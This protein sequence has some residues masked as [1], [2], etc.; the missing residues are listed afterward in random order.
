[1]GLVEYRKA[2]IENALR[3]EPDTLAAF[4]RAENYR[5]IVNGRACTI[6]HINPNSVSNRHCAVVD[7]ERIYGPGMEADTA[8]IS[9]IRNALKLKEPE[10]SEVPA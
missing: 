9:A 7:G 2:V 8:L 6:G 3:Y 4:N 5:V 1:M 10:L